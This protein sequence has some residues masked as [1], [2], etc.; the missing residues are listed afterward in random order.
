[1][2]PADLNKRLSELE[3]AD[4]TYVITLLDGKAR[5]E[6]KRFNPGGYGQALVWVTAKYREGYISTVKVKTPAVNNK[7]PMKVMRADGEVR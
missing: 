3:Q 7:P 1:M 6:T 2:M 5:V 4:A